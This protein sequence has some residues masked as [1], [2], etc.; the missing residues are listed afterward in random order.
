MTISLENA[1]VYDE[2]CLPNCW[3]L[4]AEMLNSDV[5]SVWEISEYRDD[6]QALR[7]WL[8]WLAE[9]QIPMIGFNNLGYDYPM[10]H[11]L[12][13]DPS[14]S[15][16]QLYAKN[17]AIIGGSFD[18]RF[19][20][21]IWASDRLAPQIDLM[22]LHH[23]DNKAK[24]TSLKALQVNMRSKSVLESAVPFGVPVS[25]VDVDKD[26][27]PYNQ[28]D[29]SE[30]KRFAKY[31]LPAIEFRV[32][33]VDRFS[34]DCLSWNDTKIG[35]KM[36]EQRLGE[37]V[38]Y[39]MSSGK[40]R[41]R[42]TMRSQ[43]ALKDII[44]PY[45]T[46]KN[47]EFQRIHQFMLAQVLQPE[48]A[49]DPDSPIVTKG[50]FTDLHADVGG[51]TF[52]FGT[53]GVHASVEAQRFVATADWLIRDIDVASLYPSIAIVNKLAPEHLG[54]A[55]IAEYSKI[56]EERALHAKGTYMN[57]ALK[58]AAN[59]AWGKSNSMWSVFYDPQYA[60]T[61]PINGQL[62][63]CMLVEWLLE[64]PTISLV[65]ANTDGVTYMIHKD[66]L[67][68]A[69]T[70]EKQW[71][72]FTMLTLE[73]VHFS[74]FF[75][76]DVNNFVGED[77]KGKLKQ[78][79]CYWHPDPAN[80]ADSIS[81][82]SPPAWHKDF[83]PTIVPRA[84]VAA[85]VHGIDPS[86][87]IRSHTDPFD[88]LMRVKVGRSDHLFI[89]DV[90]QQRVTR[91]Y[92]AREGGT[93]VKIS[94]PAAGGVIGQWKRAHNVTKAEYERVMAETGGQWDERVCTKNKSKWTERRT[95]IESGYQVQQCNDV[96]S[97]RFDNINYEYYIAEA[98]KLIVV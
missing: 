19:R 13:K 25:N 3:T 8:N 66:H 64:V 67:E 68:T 44:F 5:K 62:L 43:I 45:I 49:A 53:G 82:A 17:Q 81:N 94:P 21:M 24:T 90:E 78:K 84:A 87:F 86:V 48:D 80:Y 36:L 85:M 42:Q 4:A 92:V 33:L 14:L 95:T 59:G 47:P 35:E 91:Y 65:Q 52:H 70:I 46:F 72:D 96:D 97:F 89:G 98:R 1:V 27:I 23:F 54:T 39:D 41:R 34:V 11:L 37:N 20:H 40:K 63:I 7:Q 16:Q 71:Q 15:Y 55:F 58:L 61:V 83:N 6:R 32:G 79:G 93:M 50:V 60:M 76:R 18:D 88:F 69:R 51:L 56:P 29:V 74:R 31:S 9:N 75:I 57:A 73:E 77:V 30:T 38:C 26:L 22:T 2:E 28:H 10:L 12:W